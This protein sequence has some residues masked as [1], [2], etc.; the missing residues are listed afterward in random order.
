MFS[1]DLDPNLQSD[2]ISKKPGQSSRRVNLHLATQHTLLV[3]L[4]TARSRPDAPSPTSPWRPIPSF[5]GAG[6]SAREPSL[7][8][9]LVRTPF[10]APRLV[11]TPESRT[12]YGTLA[13]VSHRDNLS[14]IHP[15]L[16]KHSPSPGRTSRCGFQEDYLQSSGGR[17]QHSEFNARREDTFFA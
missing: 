16:D 7:A 14:E 10:S 11:R 4:S 2:L 6:G 5:R 9:A 15:I 17:K 3:N 12:N 1:E 8:N 13:S